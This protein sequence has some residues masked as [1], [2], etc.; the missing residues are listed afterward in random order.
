MLRRR[1]KGHMRLGTRYSLQ[2]FVL[3]PDRMF[4]RPRNSISSRNNG[5][6]GMSTCISFHGIV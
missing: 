5:T 1:I 3:H 6:N 2:A 4:Q